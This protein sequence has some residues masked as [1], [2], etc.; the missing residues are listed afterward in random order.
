MEKFI[1]KKTYSDLKKLGHNIFYCKDTIGGGQAI[2]IDRDKG[3][4][5]GGSDPRKD[6]CGIGC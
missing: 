5:I 4:L 2:F 1:P 6:G 3:V